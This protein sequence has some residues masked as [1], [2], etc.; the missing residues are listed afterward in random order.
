[1]ISSTYCAKNVRLENN[2]KIIH[3]CHSPTR[4]LHGLVTETDQKT[5]PKRFR[6]LLPLLKIFLKPLDLHAVKNLNRAGTI[7]LANSKYIQSLIEKVYQTKST[8]LYPPVEIDVFLDLPKQ[9]NQQEPYYY[10]FGRISFHKR[11]DLAIKACL[12]LGRKLVITGTAAYDAEMN[13]L[14]EI[15]LNFEKAN[16]DAVG[17]ITFTG[18]AGNQERNL[19]LSKAQAFLFPGKE[20]FGI[21]PIEA[22]ASGTPLI[23]Y[24]A[25][26]ALE[27][28]QED[29]NGVFFENQEVEDMKQAILSFEK[30]EYWDQGKIKQSAKPFDE[31][32][33]EQNF[34]QVVGF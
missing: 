15:V 2:Q 9:V 8:V 20:D 19:L 7:W 34:R 3:Y 29:F 4:F 24:Q 32:H 18:R 14:K 33:F 26:G 22:L 21:A 1:M 6:F 5:I 25:G 11:V 30:L 12:E 13:K 27:Y 10:Y 16:P 23:A 28:V 31:K 17:L